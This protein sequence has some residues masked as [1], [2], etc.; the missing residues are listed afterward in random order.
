[1]SVAAALCSL[2]LFAVVSG[3]WLVNPFVT[4][5]VPSTS[6]EFSAAEPMKYVRTSSLIN[7]TQGSIFLGLYGFNLRQ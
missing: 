5:E 3:N 1:M 6:C 4:D 7:D 2:D